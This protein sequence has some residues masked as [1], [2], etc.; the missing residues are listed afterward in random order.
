[1]FSS[2]NSS[3]NYF[4]SFILFIYANISSCGLNLNNSVSYVSSGFNLEWYVE[5]V[6]GNIFYICYAIIPTY[7]IFKFS[8]GI[9]PPKPLYW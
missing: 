4:S 2:F 8:Q 5:I 9:V 3:I 7:Y 6:D 1:M